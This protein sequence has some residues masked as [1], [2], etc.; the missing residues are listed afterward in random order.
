MRKAQ[1]LQRKAKTLKRLGIYDLLFR[2]VYNKT[3]IEFKPQ[4][5]AIK[6]E[7]EDES[8]NVTQIHWNPKGDNFTIRT[9][10]LKDLPDHSSVNST[11]HKN[12]F[13]SAASFKKEVKVSEINSQNQTKMSDSKPNKAKIDAI[14]LNNSTKL[15]LKR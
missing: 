11:K 7:V 1:R 10:Q 13:S 15:A 6:E 14:Y 5:E 8:K 4:L 12:N 9:S 3:L 2:S